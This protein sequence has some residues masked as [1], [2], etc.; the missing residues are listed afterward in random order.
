MAKFLFLLAALYAV[1]TVGEFAAIKLRGQVLQEHVV[2]VV[3]EGLAKG[4]PKDEAD[5]PGDP[6]FLTPYVKKGD[7]QTGDYSYI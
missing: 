5:G 2:N 1:C 7:Y 4:E 3:K 6:L